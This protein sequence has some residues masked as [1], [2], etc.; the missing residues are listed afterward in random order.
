MICFLLNSSWQKNKN[1]TNFLW[2]R[3]SFQKLQSVLWEKRPTFT[4]TRPNTKV[5]SCFLVGSFSF[6]DKSLFTFQQLLLLRHSFSLSKYFGI[7]SLR[8][9]LFWRQC[10]LWF[11]ES[12]LYENV[13]YLWRWGN[14]TCIFWCWF[15]KTNFMG[16][17]VGMSILSVQSGLL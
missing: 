14:P 4:K 12:S 11:Y 1:A 7:K 17:A 9:W 6:Y 5:T 13:Q 8:L 15:H 10:T 2:S 3:L 16:R